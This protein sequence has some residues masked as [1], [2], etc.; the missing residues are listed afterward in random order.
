LHGDGTYTV[1]KKGGDGIGYS[2]HKHQRG[3][4]VLAIAYNNGFI[5]ASYTIA[6]VNNNDCILLPDSLSHL[7]HIARKIG[8]SIK[9]A[10]LNLDGVFDSKDNRKR[11][12]NRG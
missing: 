2:G 6:P 9:G 4:K 7:S 12:F 3:E 10:I 11:I 8:F 1:A 5:L